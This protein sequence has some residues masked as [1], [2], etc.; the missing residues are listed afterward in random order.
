MKKVNKEYWQVVVFNDDKGWEVLQQLCYSKGEAE[1]VLNECQECWANDEFSIVEGTDFVTTKCKG[2]GTI[3]A[4][5]C[6]DAHG[7][8]TGYWCDP[9]YNSSKYPYRKDK[10][11]TMETHGHG[12][13][14][15]DDY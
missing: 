7:I 11:P 12:D 13:Y 8:T 1:S 10:Y 6:S 5:E 2:C 9:C 3:E 14:L 4:D 15:E